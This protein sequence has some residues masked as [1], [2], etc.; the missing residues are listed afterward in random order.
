MRDPAVGLAKQGLKCEACGMNVHQKCHRK[1]ANCCGINEKLMTEAL[2]MMESIQQA[3]CLR[4]TE[5]IFR[6]G[7]VEIGLPCSM[8]GEAQLPYIP[9]PGKRGSY[10]SHGRIGVSNSSALTVT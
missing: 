1:V 9:A 5:H 2:A 3:R 6:E 4:D 10:P 8:K 7:P